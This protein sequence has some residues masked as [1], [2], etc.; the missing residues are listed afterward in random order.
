MSFSQSKFGSF[1]GFSSRPLFLSLHDVYKLSALYQHH[2]LAK[3]PRYKLHDM[4]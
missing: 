2:M 1:F 3:Y 4:N